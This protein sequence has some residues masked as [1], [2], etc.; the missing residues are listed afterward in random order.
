VIPMHF[1]TFPGIETDAQ[2]FKR[3]VEEKTSATVVVLEPGQ[4]HMTG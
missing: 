1:D 2:A 4:S 3:E